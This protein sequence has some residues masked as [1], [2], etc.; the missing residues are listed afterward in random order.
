MIRLKLHL[1]ENVVD[2][3]YSR[4]CNKYSDKSNRRNL[5]LSLSMASCA[6]GA[7]SSSPLISDFVDRSSLRGVDNFF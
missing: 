5:G 4:L 6:L 7:I 3:L 2:M 1:I